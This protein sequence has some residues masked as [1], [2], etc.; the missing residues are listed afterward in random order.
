MN[1]TNETPIQGR[2]GYAGSITKADVGQEVTLC[3]WVHRR[4][5]HGGV[6][7]IDLRDRGGI[8]QIVF[9]PN[10]DQ[11]SHAAAEGLRNE[12]VIG[13]RGKVRMRPEGMRNPKMPSGDVEVLVHQLVV[14][15]HAE[16]L[17]FAIEG[18]T[19]ITENMRLKY[20]YL[21]LRRPSLQQNFIFRHRMIG[22]MRRVLDELAFLDIE[23]PFLTKST[24]EG[25]RDYLVPSRV[26]P[27]SFYALPQSPQLFKQLLMVSGFDRYYQVVRCFRDEDLRADRQPEFTQLDLEMSF[28]D[29][30]K[31]FSVIERI[32][33]VLFKELLHEP[34]P[35]S[36]PRITYDEAMQRYG[37]DKP[38]R[39]FPLTIENLSTIFA[40]T[41][42]KVFKGVLDGGGTIRGFAAPQ[43]ATLSRTQLEK[44]KDVVEPMGVKGVV[45]IKK[46]NGVV[47]SSIEKFLSPDEIKALSEKFKLDN[48]QVGIMI[49]GDKK[50][51]LLAL[52]V[53]RLHL[54]Q[55]L[56]LKPEKK[57]DL[58]WVTDFPLFERASDGSIT[59]A[60]HPFTAPVAEH[61]DRIK[62]DPLS[63]ASESYDLVMN[64]TELGSGS[65]RIHDSKLQHEIFET[66]QL[67]EEEI[68]SRFGFFIEALKYGTPP[69]GG[70]ALGIDRLTSLFVGMPSIR[71]VIAFPKTQKGTCLTT[72]APTA[73]TPAQLKELSLKTVE[74]REPQK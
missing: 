8:A 29:R 54:I 67:T 38:D 40:A 69:H 62:S 49:A 31:I 58:F 52:G 71:D 20:R 63:V 34:L 14:F 46:E 9:D 21:D 5:D 53:L 15:N 64:G 6:I 22:Y 18:E 42:F 32:C 39:R 27:G 16:A 60:H 24:P 65:I 4:R 28:V 33:A 23:T 59:S 12:Y 43:A 51:T 11:Q 70:I 25:A 66:L 56:G 36:L 47:K 35:S 61:R 7:F 13:I 45:W 74:V 48:D 2:S 73:A 19:E 1:A 3:G 10:S 30:D 44:L 17:P 41:G 68:Q 55:Q 37:T 50:Q 57:F 72:N 26:T